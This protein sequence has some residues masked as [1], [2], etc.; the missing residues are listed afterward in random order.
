MTL[1]IFLGICLGSPVVLDYLQEN[2]IGTTMPNLNTAI[3]SGIS[4]P[5]PPL[6][7][8]EAISRAFEAQHA[9]LVVEEQRR[10]RLDSLFASLLDSQITG[11]VRVPVDVP[12]METDGAHRG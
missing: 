3:L 11:A 12:G 2:A 9:K 10:A 7:E 8:Q 5:I 6:A 4:V 1:N